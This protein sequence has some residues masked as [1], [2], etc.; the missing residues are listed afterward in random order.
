MLSNHTKLQEFENRL[1][2]AEPNFESRISKLERDL[3]YLKS[4]QFGSIEKIASL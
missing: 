2:T 3:K 1:I 4:E